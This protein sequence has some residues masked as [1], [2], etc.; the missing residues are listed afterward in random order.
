M[1][2]Q[3]MKHIETP[4]NDTLCLCAD[5][6]HG[7]GCITDVVHHIKLKPNCKLV[8]HLVKLV[9]KLVKLVTRKAPNVIC[10]KVKKELECMECLE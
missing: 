7:L 9:T 5:T 3:L 8:I 2:M 6:F 1:N 4:M 10:S